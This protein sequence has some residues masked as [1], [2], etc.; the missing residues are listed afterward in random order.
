MRMPNVPPMALSRNKLPLVNAVRFTQDLA[1]KH[2]SVGSSTFR[3]GKLGDMPL[4][5]MS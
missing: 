1:A 2:G 3:R 5:S 4:R